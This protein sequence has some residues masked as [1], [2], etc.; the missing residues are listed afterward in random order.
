MDGFTLCRELRSRPAAAHVPILMVTGL[1]DLTLHCRC[2]AEAGATD[3]IAKP[4]EWRLI[5]THRIHVVYR[6]YDMLEVAPQQRGRG[7]APP[8]TRPRRPIAPSDFLGRAELQAAH[9]AP[10]P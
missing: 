1:D 9:A 4:F 8:T 2:P 7:C 3:F 6:A 10:A 5:L